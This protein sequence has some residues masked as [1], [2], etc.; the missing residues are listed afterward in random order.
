MSEFLPISSAALVERFHH[1]QVTFLVF[2][3]YQ[4]TADVYVECVD[5]IGQHER[6]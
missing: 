4:Q 1:E 2:G 5:E 3:E 6:G